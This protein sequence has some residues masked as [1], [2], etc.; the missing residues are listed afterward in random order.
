MTDGLIGLVEKY[1]PKGIIVD[2]NLLLLWI[3]GG[4]DES[5]IQSCRR[6]QQFVPEDFRS[7]NAL[8]QR[9][10]THV[11]TPNVLTEVSNF[12]GQLSGD[13]RTRSYQRLAESVTTLDERYIASARLVEDN[14]FE[15][16]GLSDCS[17]KL[18]AFAGLLVL[19]DDFDLYGVLNASGV[20][21]I[22]FNHIRPYGWN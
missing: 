9:F 19:T 8:L 11:C 18:V 5:L 22:N 15:R 7:L 13:N 3:V 10:S 4:V 17:I 14:Y 2:T 6:T 1:R 21:C 12:V 16:I 20:D